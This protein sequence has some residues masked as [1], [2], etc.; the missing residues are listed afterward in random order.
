MY[1][2]ETKGCSRYILTLRVKGHQLHVQ[3]P[4]RRLKKWN[5][6]INASKA[7]HLMIE[8]EGEHLQLETEIVRNITNF[9]Y[10]GV[11]ITANGDSNQEIKTRIGQATAVTSQLNSL[12]WSTK[13]TKRNNNRM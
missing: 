11:A 1:H 8:Y 5:L 12:L 4:D 6:E 3:K 2:L 7:A 10:L 13:I 9:K